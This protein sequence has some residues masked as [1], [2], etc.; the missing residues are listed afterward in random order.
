M[1]AAAR[2]A[3]TQKYPIAPKGFAPQ[4]PEFEIVG[5]FATDPLKI[6]NIESGDGGKLGQVVTVTTNVNH[7]LTGGTPIKIRGINVSDYN[8]STKVSNVIDEQD[9]NIHYHLLDQ[10]YQ[11]V[12]QVD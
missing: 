1:K 4:R 2:R 6:S 7:N 8:I 12:K 5:A 11:Q 3:I 10:T 9:F